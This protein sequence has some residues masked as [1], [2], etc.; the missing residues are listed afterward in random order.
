[1][2]AFKSLILICLDY[3][4]FLRF[5][6]INILI[7]FFSS[8]Y[9]DG[10]FCETFHSNDDGWRDCGSCGKVSS[11]KLLLLQNNTDFQ[12][13]CC[14][15][16]Y[17]NCIIRQ[18]IN[19][20]CIFS[21]TWKNLV[22]CIHVNS[23]IFQMQLVHCGCIVSFSTHLLLDFGGIICMECSRLNFLLVGENWKL[24]YFT[25]LVHE[26]KCCYLLFWVLTFCKFS[27]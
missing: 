8:A 23:I 13:V 17:Y 21:L 6:L 22:P 16:F 24:F 26:T 14:L 2:E 27:S 19:M 5:V 25:S 3:D 10:R 11:W 7:F 15:L 1:M 20:V 18:V 12:P 9:D 4:T